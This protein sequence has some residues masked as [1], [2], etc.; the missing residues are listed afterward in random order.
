[1]EA[2]ESAFRVRNQWASI[3]APERGQFL[4]VVRGEIFRQKQALGA[5]VSA[6]VGKTYQEGLGEIQ[7][8]IDVCDYA[9]G[10]SRMLPGSIFP[11][12]RRGHILLESW[13]PAGVTGVITAFNFPAAVFGW[14]AALAWICGNPVIW[15]PALSTSLTA[16]ALT[17]LIQDVIKSRELPPEICTLVVGNGTDIGT[18]IVSSEKIPL[19]SFTG[20]T[21]VGRSI[22]S[23]VASRFGRSILELG[24]NNAIIVMPDADLDLALRSVLFAAVG[25]TGQRCTSARR[26]LIHT[27]IYENFKARLVQAYKSVKIGCPFDPSAHCGPLHTKAALEQYTQILE[28]EIPAQ[29]GRVLGEAGSLPQ[30]KGYFAKPIL[31]EGLSPH[32]PLLQEEA[33]VPIIYLLPFESFEEAV[34][35]NNGVPQALSSSIFTKDLGHVM[36]WTCDASSKVG[37]ECGIVNVNAPTN[38]AE[39]GGAFGGNKAT[40]WG[41]ESGSTSW[42]QY[43][44]RHTCTINYSKELPLSQGIKFG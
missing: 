33:F 28:K 20:S 35:I 14:N 7:E 9:I 38:G 30:M 29:G 3:P 8:I 4:A 19:I 31:V 16:I 13:R 34:D 15:K 42:Q 27:S 36:K 2:I 18:A 37:S 44:T 12:E 41:R 17:R 11:S 32:A 24:G 5:L 22:G 40:G 23:A 21:N 43:M 1:M 25:T 6:E 10:L 26:L 39:I